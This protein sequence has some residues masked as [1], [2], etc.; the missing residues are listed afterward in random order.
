MSFK[1]LPLMV[2]NYRQFFSRDAV[3]VAVDL[4]GRQ[5]SRESE[6]GV[7]SGQI[8]QVGAYEGGNITPSR[9]G[10]LYAPGTLFLMPYRGSELLNIATDRRAY[11]SCVEIRAVAFHDG[12]V[13]GAGKIT[14]F[15][16][17]N[18]LDGMLLGEHLKINGK[19][20]DPSQAK[21]IRDGSD[22]CLG[23]FSIK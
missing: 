9:E 5:L 2:S 14:D 11:P 1:I 7:T 6:I 12:V 16:D 17:L 3:E 21:R 8:V 15:L 23:Y 22:N 13:E 18:G 19:A 4:L 20:A 10:M